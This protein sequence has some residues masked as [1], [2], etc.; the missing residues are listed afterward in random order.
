VLG[1]LQV[2]LHAEML[3]SIIKILYLKLMHGD[4]YFRKTQQIFNC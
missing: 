1:V 3:L 2:K 4:F